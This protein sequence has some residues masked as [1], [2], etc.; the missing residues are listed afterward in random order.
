[1][2]S[3][4]V[5][6]WSGQTEPDARYD[7]HPPRPEGYQQ[8]PAEGWAPQPPYDG[9]WHGA[10]QPAP[11]PAAQQ[12]YP[13]QPYPA[14][15]YS[16]PPHS[17]PPYS[18]SPHSTPPY[19]TPAHVG[20]PGTPQTGYPAGQ[21]AGYPPPHPGGGQGQS[22][23][24]ILIL[25]IVGLLVLCLGGGGVAYVAYE[26]DQSAD[27]KPTPTAAPT[28]GP[29]T[30]PS[31]TA[32]SPATPSPGS[33]PAAQIRV[34]TPETLA[35]RPKSTDATLKKLA[36]DMVQELRG[37]VRGEN[38]VVG[39]FYGSPSD[40]NMVMVIAASTFVLNPTKELDDTVRSMSKGMAVTG[41]TTIAPG[42][43]GGVAKCGD[44]KSAEVSLG[45]CSWADHGSVGV[46]V[47]FFSS[48]AASA[49]EFV[50][51]RGEIEQQS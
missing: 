4:P 50:T 18:T 48:A 43:L 29:A 49:A 30:T 37:S 44:G 27:P 42:P 14:P 45:V 47:M 35:G 8:P 16:T 11:P 25:G 3:P 51:I 31:A 24:L 1:M 22:R 21:Y 32:S 5:D 19:S 36:E 39:A 15:P 7:F 23:Q 12:P 28:T 17:T 9:Q 40:R 38:D 34:V 26:R 20:Y 2:S 41:M 10:P 6:P 46:I 33:S 13:T